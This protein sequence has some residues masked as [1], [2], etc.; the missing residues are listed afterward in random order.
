MVWVKMHP[1]I[2][3]AC[4]A[5]SCGSKLLPFALQGWFMCSAHVHLSFNHKY[6]YLSSRC[7]DY[8]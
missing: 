4:L 7:L 3:T 8:E 2:H 6:V 1:K 5:E